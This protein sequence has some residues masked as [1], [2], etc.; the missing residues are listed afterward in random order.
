MLEEF[1]LFNSEHRCLL[2]APIW[3]L[4]GIWLLVDKPLRKAGGTCILLCSWCTQV[5][6]RPPGKVPC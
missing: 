4:T 3:V 1:V 5:E 6:A 2:L